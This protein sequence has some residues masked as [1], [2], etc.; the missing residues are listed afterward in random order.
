MSSLRITHVVRSDSFAGVERYITDVAAE[1]AGRGHEVSVIGGDPDLVR[2]SLPPQVRHRAA[3][4]TREVVAALIAGGRQ[5]VVHA[6]MSAAELAA[7]VTRPLHGAP[8]VATRHFAGRRGHSPVSRAV[9][10]GV[11]R[12]L[13]LEIAT[14]DF[15]A[16]KSGPGSVVLHHGV[17]SQPEGSHRDRTV[18]VM[19]R[20]EPEKD[21]DIALRA[22]ATSGLQEDGWRLQLAGRGSLLEAMRVLA[23]ELQLDVEFLGFVP[24]PR[25]VLASAGILLAPTPVEAFG[26]TV[27]EA[28]AV[29]LA[30]VAANGGGHVETLGSAAF[31]FPPRDVVAAATLLRRLA[32]DP[33]ERARTGAALRRRQQELFT[34]SGHVLDLINYYQRVLGTTLGA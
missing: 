7:V 2:G 32:G 33:D 29:G 18:L 25:A 31:L 23:G 9:T 22:F 12:G 14:S 16:D 6:H 30:V 27:V 1:L 8:V 20:F 11:A 4:T 19:Q 10:R 34:I 17:A 24:D 26:F 3:A 13:S 21:T 5:D 28:M 15:V